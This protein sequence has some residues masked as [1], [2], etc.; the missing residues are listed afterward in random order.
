MLFSK[1]NN[2]QLINFCSL[3]EFLL[4]EINRQTVL[5]YSFTLKL[6][7]IYSDKSEMQLGDSK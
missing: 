5:L 3:S 7:C 4:P 1:S 2:V 6:F